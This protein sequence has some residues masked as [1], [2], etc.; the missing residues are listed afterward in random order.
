MDACN[1]SRLVFQK[2]NG[3]R[4]MLWEDFAQP[5]PDKRSLSL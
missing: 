1:T 4:R 5:L 3:V 2:T